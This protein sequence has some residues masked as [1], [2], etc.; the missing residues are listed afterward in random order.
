[1]IGDGQS[2]SYPGSLCPSLFAV[3]VTYYLDDYRLDNVWSWINY[4]GYATA[5]L[6][7]AVCTVHAHT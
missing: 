6:I 5:S 1:M 3:A 4:V 2:C 7:C